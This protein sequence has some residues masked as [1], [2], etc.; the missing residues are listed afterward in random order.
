MKSYSDARRSFG[1]RSARRLSRVAIAILTFAQVF[2]VSP[3]FASA[4]VPELKFQQLPAD[5][6]N[7]VEGIHQSC[8]EL[9]DTSQ[10]SDPMQGITVIDLDSNGSKALLVDSEWLCNSWIKAGNC[11]NRGCDLKIWKQTNQLSWRPIFN[12]HVSRKFVS[13]DEKNVLRL[14]AVSIYAGDPHCRPIPGRKYTSGESCDALVRYKAGGW[15][16]EK[17]N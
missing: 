1:V 14:M 7:Y 13:T 15:V 2:C 17:I 9:D 6:R 11:S 10:P 8:K 12:E 4:E 5:L 3:R 16:W